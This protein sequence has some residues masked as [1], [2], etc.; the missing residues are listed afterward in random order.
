MEAGVEAQAAQMVTAATAVFP[1]AAA[2]RAADLLVL[3]MAVTIPL[4]LAAVPIL[5]ATAVRQ[6]ELAQV[7]ER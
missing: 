5:A 3:T 4:D 6:R 7:E 2:V 1:A